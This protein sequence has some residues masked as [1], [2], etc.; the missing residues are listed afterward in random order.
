MRAWLLAVAVARLKGSGDAPAT[1]SRKAGTRAL[2]QQHS[3]VQAATAVESTATEKA[4]VVA[5]AGTKTRST[6]ATGVKQPI[7]V[8][9]IGIGNVTTPTMLPPPPPV[10]NPVE[11]YQ[12]LDT[13]IGDYILKQF[14][15]PPTVTPPPLQSQL[16]LA[17]ACP[18]M[19]P[20]PDIMFVSA[21]NGC[22][23]GVGRS[24]RWRT[25]TNDTLMAWTEAS[26]STTGVA[27][28]FVNPIG[29]SF[30]SVKQ[31]FALSGSKVDFLDCGLNVLYTMTETV[32][33]DSSATD[34]YVCETYKICDG[35][36]YLKYDI[37]KAGSPGTGAFSALVPI[38]AKEFTL[39]DK[40]STN[41]VLVASKATAWTSREPECPDYEKE[42][43]LSFKT[44]NG[45][46]ADP[47]FRWVLGFA[48]TA[49]SLRD[50]DR[51]NNGKVHVNPT[52]A[53]TWIIVAVAIFG[54][55]CVVMG[56]LWAFDKY[57]KEDVTIFC[58]KVESSFFPT[59]MYKNKYY[60]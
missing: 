45:H 18:L 19:L 3:A 35:S 27:A 57:F 50:E 54:G 24:G 47:G 22:T 51:S 38:F 21:P 31:E 12:P 58:L 56:L 14:V 43:S 59:T 44:G 40:A 9:T 23:S 33:L 5:G 46:L 52:E 37:S 60:S 1:P 16:D 15:E 17:N 36:I 13:A 8:P 10:L 4:S 2:L 53:W 20:A 42:W 30:G 48:V 25:A 49:M 32:F 34:P 55:S 26:Y 39:Y 29:D 41:P 6:L 7:F 28:S 11:D